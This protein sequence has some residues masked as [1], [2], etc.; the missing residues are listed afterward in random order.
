VERL[1]AKHRAREAS[2]DASRRAIRSSA[3]AIR[4]AHRGEE[5]RAEELVADAA[6]ALADAAKAVADHPDV[7]HAGFLLDA[8]KEYAEARATLAFLSD[9]PLPTPEELGIGDAA[10]LNGLAE[11]VGE[12]RRHLLDQLRAGRL[13]RSEALLGIMDDIYAVL[14]SVDF[15]E[16]VT[17][18]LR[19]STDVARA[20]IERTR[21]DLTA[22]LVQARLR[23][24]LEA[25]LGHLDGESSA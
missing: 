23:D 24:A 11:A 17:S 18:G 7:E 20:I 10:Y 9:R 8:R 16:G 22:A 25:H 19:R 1:A 21:G 5:S 12:L 15:P 2:F 13:E 4:A 3:N 6:Q 14:V